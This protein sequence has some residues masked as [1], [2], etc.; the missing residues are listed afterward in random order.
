METVREL[1]ERK[2]RMEVKRDNA[3]ADKD[4]STEKLTAAA[5]QLRALKA[6]CGAFMKDF[7]EQQV[8]LQFQM[9]QLRDAHAILSGAT[10]MQMD[11]ADNASLLQLQTSET[12]SNS[13]SK[14][15]RSLS[16]GSLSLPSQLNDLENIAHALA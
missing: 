1:A 14:T 15:T 10:L 4:S 13:N 6:E 5:A 3:Q 2:G 16:T 8:K 7:K 9:G 12:N 11:S